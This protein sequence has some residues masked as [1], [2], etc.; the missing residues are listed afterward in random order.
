MPSPPFRGP[1]RPPSGTWF[2][3]PREAALRPSWRRDTLRR[4][5]TGHPPRARASR[6]SPQPGRLA[7]QLIEARLVAGADPARAHHGGDA[8]GERHARHPPERQ[9]GARAA[10]GGLTDA[11]EELVP[12]ARRRRLAE[13]GGEARERLLVLV[14]GALALG[15]PAGAMSGE[16]ARVLALERVEDVPG[17]QLVER[18]V[19]GAHVRD[20]AIPRSRSMPSR[21]RVFT[22]PSGRPRRAEISLCVIPCRYASSITARCSGGSSRKTPR[23][24]SRS[25]TREPGLPVASGTATAVSLAGATNISSLLRTERTRSIPR[26]RA[27][28]VT[29]AS[30]EPRRGSY[31]PAARQ[32]S[33]QTSCGTSAAS[34]TSRSMRRRRPKASGA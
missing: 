28:T 29:H 31:C 14:D 33:Q 12:H 24:V 13:V 8:R 21:M 34:S 22:V 16:A 9:A 18:L 1:L 10:G 3:P 2:N 20:P 30:G 5:G 26:L 27:R 6:R 25:S 7:R 19:R 11:L 23:A 17:D 15:A 32:S 4:S